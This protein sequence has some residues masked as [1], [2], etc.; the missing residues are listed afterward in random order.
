MLRATE[1]HSRWRGQYPEHEIGWKMIQNESILIPSTEDAEAGVCLSAGC[2][3]WTH[4]A[5]HFDTHFYCPGLSSAVGTRIQTS[6]SL[7]PQDLGWEFL[8]LG[9]RW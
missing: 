5:G 4:R 3:S 2:L 9:W 7:V 1:D 8:E 6:W